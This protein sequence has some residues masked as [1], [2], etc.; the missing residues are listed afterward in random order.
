MAKTAAS[1][2]ITFFLEP[3]FLMTLLAASFLDSFARPL[4]TNLLFCPFGN[5]RGLLGVII[6]SWLGF[7]KASL[8]VMEPSS[9]SL[10]GKRSRSGCLRPFRLIVF[11]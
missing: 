9:S 8:W 6:D 2:C 1:C 7:D 5:S 10:Q 11:V 4:K 3:I